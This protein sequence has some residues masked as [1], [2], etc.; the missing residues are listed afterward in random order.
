MSI[1]I[2]HIPNSNLSFAYLMP[3]CNFL[4]KSSTLSVLLGELIVGF[5]K[6]GV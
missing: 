3:A 5:L 2:I 1:I 4:E 6:R